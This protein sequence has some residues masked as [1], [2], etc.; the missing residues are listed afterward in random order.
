MTSLPQSKGNSLPQKTTS[1]WLQTL[2]LVI[3]GG[4]VYS[5]TLNGSFHFDDFTN[6]VNNPAIR[7][8]SPVAGWFTFNPRRWVGFLTF[9]LNYHFHGLDVAG[10]HLV[11]ISIH[12]LNGLLV[13]YFTGM[14][15]R[16]SLRRENLSENTR[17]AV[18]SEYGCLC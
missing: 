3:T 18:R 7:D 13:W 2:V 11:N 9:A 12:I 10:Y 15:L 1:F 4:V 8:L 5:N 16:N 17:P 6:I 14:L